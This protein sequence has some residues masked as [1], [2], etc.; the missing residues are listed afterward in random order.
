MALTCTTDH[1]LLT[2]ADGIR[3]ATLVSYALRF[4]MPKGLWLSCELQREAGEHLFQ[5]DRGTWPQPGL[6][7]R[8]H[9]ASCA[10]PQDMAETPQKDIKDQIIVL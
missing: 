9:T 3:A 5:A 1:P 6:C 2:L 7:A 4:K 8:L 10:S